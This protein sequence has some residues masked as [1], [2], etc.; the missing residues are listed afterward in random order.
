MPDKERYGAEMLRVLKPGGILVVADWNQRDDRQ[1]P[2]RNQF[3]RRRDYRQF[4]NPSSS[5]LVRELYAR[6]IE[7]F[8]Y[9]FGDEA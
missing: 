3:G 5:G 2:R 1:V 7:R 8:G 9:R 4:Y 6:E